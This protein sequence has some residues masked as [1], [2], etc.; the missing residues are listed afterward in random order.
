VTRV[1]TP[2]GK[3]SALET[4]VLRHA[5]EGRTIEATAHLLD[6]TM[7]AVQ[8]AR[9]RL[10]GKLG[11]NSMSHA[12]HLAWQSGIFRRERHGDHAGFVAHTR[13]G[14]T[15]CEACKSA[16]RAYRNQLRTTRKAAA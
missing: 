2:T 6:S 11:A 9:H 4:S 1:A 3:L 14:E 13:R 12:V 16:E 8:D 15:P 10:M 5:A 7:P